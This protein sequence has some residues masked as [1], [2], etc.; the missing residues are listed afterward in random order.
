MGFWR[1]SLPALCLLM[2]SLSPALAAVP[3]EIFVQQNIDRGIALLTDKS[4][5]DADRRAKLTGLLTEILDTKAMALFML[6]AAREQAVASDLDTYAEAYR[7]FMIAGY[8]SQLGGYG[9]QSIKVTG[10]TERAPGD[11][12]VTAVVVD[13]A[14]PNDPNP[15]AVGFRVKDEGGGKFA[16]VDASIEGIWLGL[17]QR[18]EF[19]AYLSQHANSVATLAAHLQDVTSRNAVPAATAHK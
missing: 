8:E 19:G 14:S 10:S 18:A 3:V 6:G 7:A 15:L 17:A 9:G 16:V 4:F 12:I 13:P 1:V 11:W 5:S 2:F